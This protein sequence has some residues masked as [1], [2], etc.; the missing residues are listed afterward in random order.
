M[1]GFALHFSRYLES[2]TYNGNPIADGWYNCLDLAYWIESDSTGAVTMVWNGSG[3]NRFASD[4]V[5]LTQDAA[6]LMGYDTGAQTSG[7][8]APQSSFYVSDATFKYLYDYQGSG[9]PVTRS[10]SVVALDGTVWSYNGSE[11]R[12]EEFIFELI[13]KTDIFGTSADGD[14][15]A[16]L[17]EAVD[18]NSGIKFVLL[19]GDVSG[20]SY[21]PSGSWISGAQAWKLSD[22]EDFETSIERQFEEYDKYFRFRIRSIYQDTGDPSA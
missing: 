19:T 6:N 8:R 4:S 22:A 21:D 16:T 13:E 7:A 5:N 15:T 11:V 1:S 20:T 10:Q 2:Q 9:R 14:T 3:G 17:E 18:I 12:F